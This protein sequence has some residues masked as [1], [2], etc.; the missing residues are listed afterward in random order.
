MKNVAFYDICT[1]DFITDFITLFSL[2]D[3]EH[4]QR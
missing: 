4:S 3:Q 2:Q 1:C